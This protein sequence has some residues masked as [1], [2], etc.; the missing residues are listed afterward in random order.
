MPKEGHNPITC[1]AYKLYHYN[2]ENYRHTTTGKKKGKK[3]PSQSKPLISFQ[4]TPKGSSIQLYQPTNENQ[5][6]ISV[7]KMFLPDIVS[8]L[9]RPYVMHLLEDFK[10]LFESKSPF[11]E[12]LV[13]FK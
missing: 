7:P 2:Q 6:I 5:S 13:T 1:I 3:K 4:W 12:C 11:A 10:E 8:C 9:S